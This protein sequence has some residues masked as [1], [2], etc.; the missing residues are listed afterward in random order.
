MSA[1][2]LKNI[3]KQLLTACA[4]S[5]AVARFMPLH[6]GHGEQELHQ[7][8]LRF[9]MRLGSR[10]EHLIMRSID[11]LAT[12]DWIYRRDSTSRLVERLAD[13]IM[14]AFNGEVLTA[15][16][17]RQLVTSIVYGGYVVAVESVPVPARAQRDIGRTAQ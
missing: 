17:G 10:Y 2:R 15:A 7:H 13:S 6:V 3:I 9:L 4:A 1:I 14:N 16:E 5:L 8:L 11:F 12:R